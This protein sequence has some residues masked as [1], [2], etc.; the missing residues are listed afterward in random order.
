MTTGDADWLVRAAVL[1]VFELDWLEPGLTDVRSGGAE[2][3]ADFLADSC[4]R[5]VDA[6]GIPRWRLRDDE[7]LRVLRTVPRQ[8]LFAAV[9]AAPRRP[10]EPV[11]HVLEQY[12]HG[13]LPP[14]EELGAAEL[15]GVLQL[16]RWLGPGTGLPTQQDV[17]SRL[18]WLNLLAPLRRLFARGFVGREDVL[19]DLAAHVDAPLPRAPFV[20]EGVGGSGKSTVLA[21]LIETVNARGEL[22]CYASFDRSWL[23]QGG[24]WSLIDEIVRQTGM[25]LSGADPGVQKQVTQLRRQVQRFAQRVGYSDV[26]SRVTQQVESVPQVLLEDLGR[27][28]TP[29]RL[30]LVLDTL[31]ELARRDVS[32]AQACSTFLEQLGTVLPGLRVVAAG[33]AR[34]RFGFAT[35]Q[36]WQLAGLSEQDSVRL[37]RQLTGMVGDEELLLGIVRL[38]RGNPLSLHLA[39]DVLRRTGTDPTRL[40]AIG[41][42]DI[43]GQLYS[44]LLEH[45]KDRRAQAV[46]HPGLVVRRI[47]PDVIREVLSEPCGIAPLSEHDAAALFWALQSEATLCEPS[48]DGDGALVHR[49]DVRA[50]MLPA[51]TRARPAVARAIHE[52][53]VRYYE[54]LAPQPQTTNRVARRE[55]LYH[56]L[57]LKQPRPVLDRRWLPSVADELAAVVDELPAESQLYL[58]GQVKGLRLDPEVR[59]EA[60]DGQWRHSVR[61]AVES[62][63]E[64]GQSEE[65]LQLLQERRGHDGRVLLPGLEIEA[66]ERLGRV[67]DALDLAE[68]EQQRASGLGQDARVRDLILQQARLLE[69]RS[70]F[71]EARG[72]LDRLA[73]LDRAARARSGV[74]DEEVR[75][76]ELVVLTSLLRITRQLNPPDRDIETLRTETVELAERTPL[77]V[78]TRSPS[79]LRD[80][81]A[82]IGDL[83]TRVLELATTV[84]G[85]DL[86]Q[87]PEAEAPGASTS[88]EA[89]QPTAAQKQF[90]TEADHSQEYVR[91]GFHLSSIVNVRQVDDQ[92]WETLRPLLYHATTLD[93]QVPVGSRTDFL[94]VPR[95]FV[96]FIP[97]YGRYTKA[98]ILHDYLCSVVVP[99]GRISRIDAD[100]I[101]RQ[102]MRELGVPF[103]HRWIM[104][105]AVRLG[106][107]TNPA[108]RK[109]WW[110]EAWRVALVAAVALP[111]VGPAAA[112]IVIT[113][114]VRY[115]V[116]LLVWIPLQAA[117]RSREWRN[118]RAKKVN[119]PVLRW[120]L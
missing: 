97:R 117:H 79:L 64:R 23:V 119:R 15:A 109:D 107:L 75:I 34:P 110:K 19:A 46:A 104:W 100:G 105:A 94:S 71:Q 91:L 24:A 72:L 57:M 113:L 87:A 88:F 3:L 82:E 108:G 80:L 66:L 76:R 78:L 116:E 84:R 9:E 55:E 11:Q 114:V 61:P 10:D 81:A 32:L 44:R 92:D 69:R 73:R 56:R 40:I 89:E 2:R 38:T 5:V 37:L 14:V 21:R 53:A 102:A 6:Q 103:L 111:I 70:R 48:I 77:R 51:I 31:E 27:L 86:Q 26:A 106:A 120:R 90:I 93:I 68:T 16:E 115:V 29:R 4:E 50:L 20:I 30:V 18:D 45:I 36:V 83:S 65:A 28:V 1:S 85:I 60:D 25:Q 63:L 22:V 7:R 74:L 54:R 96:W 43:Q 58:T 118:R 112:V 17:E 33:R 42:G 62:L 101:L 59:A 41:E 39:G 13:T 8:E 47:T 49:S 12:L 35:G 99:A 95:M 52:A 98:A 67:S